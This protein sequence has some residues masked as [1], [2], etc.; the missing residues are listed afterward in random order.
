MSFTGKLQN[1]CF[2]M[3]KC[4]LKKIKINNLKNSHYALL[5]LPGNAIHDC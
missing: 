3:F 5:Y 2:F 4:F 1:I